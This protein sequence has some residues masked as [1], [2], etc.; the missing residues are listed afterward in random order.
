MARITPVQ[1]ELSQRIHWLVR[2]RWIASASVL[3][4]TLAATKVLDLPLDPLPLYLIAAAIAIYNSWFLIALKWTQ[5]E[6]STRHPAT[7]RWIAN[8]QIL[9]DLIFLTLVIHFSGGA[10]NPFAFYYVFHVVISALLLSRG[11]TFLMATAASVLFG[12]L[13]LAESAGLLPFQPLF[14]LEWIDPSRSAYLVSAALFV[15]CTTIYLVAYMATSI[16]A[17]LRE[18]D[19]E[20]LLLS[21]E[22]EA[23]ARELEQACQVLAE[24]E[25]LKSQYTRKVAHEIRAPMA[26]I[27]STLR[28]VLEGILGEMPDKQREMIARAERRVQGLLSL[29][30]D[31]LTLSRTR[32]SQQLS[33]AKPVDLVDLVEKVVSLQ[34][35]RAADKRINLLVHHSGQVMEVVA[36]PESL[37]QVVTNLVANAINYTPRWGSVQVRLGL[38]ADGIEL[39]VADTGIGIAPDD[40]PKIFNEF[41]RAPNA[42]TYSEEGTG[43]GLS[44]VRSVIDA[45]GGDIQVESTVGQGTTFRIRL[46]RGAGST[47][48]TGRDD[49]GPSGRAPS[50][51]SHM[52]QG[53][54]QM[55]VGAAAQQDIRTMAKE[56][57]KDWVSSLL[58]LLQNHGPVYGP[59]RKNSG[60]VF[61][62]IAAP[63][64]LALEYGTTVLPPKKLL[65]KP[66]ETLFSARLDKGF[67]IQEPAPQEPQVLFGVHSCDLS[68]IMLLDKVYRQSYVDPI[69]AARRDSTLIVAMSCVNPP[70]DRC[71]CGSMGTG[72]SPSAGYDLLFT[73]LGD[74]VLL[75]IGSARGAAVV[76]ELDWAD[77]SDETRARKDSLLADCR[78]RMPR[79]MNTTGLPRLLNENMDHP[80]WM[81]L[82][83]R[84][85]S[86]ANCAMSCPSCYCYNVVDQIGLDVS[87]VQRTRSWDA[88]LLL[89]FAEV[90]GG[91]F[92]KERDARVKQFMYH[93]LSYWV[94]QYGTFGCV[95]CG[96]CINA[97]PAGIDITE[98]AREIR[99]EAR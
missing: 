69:Y 85:L 46:P 90:H 64:D 74:T 21:S 5:G 52:E 58:P 87:T 91:N 53:G 94:D 70:Y 39:L 57:G 7:P 50:P 78:D 75:E 12:G 23:K 51:L 28:V 72:P 3:Y 17:R 15:F 83:D 14:R 98:T 22:M 8:G 27:Q 66:M 82:R 43:L 42:R 96:R 77:A 60:Y 19:R 25:R 26:A 55:A 45:I 79:R 30:G 63:A 33:Q 97:C 24:Q 34:A 67:E 6:F 47:D 49:R 44:I 99:G 71:F 81:K 31:L 54:G 62:L 59:T 88:C 4:G 16:V 32:E 36:N 10:A 65:L 1:A 92:R 80:L 2:L 56:H 84:C 95:G 61:S 11:D 20:I 40:L 93:K 89:E 13:V 48:L 38:L 73:D 76:K 29:V 18:R 68:A 9:V 86:C 37:E 35:P 41:Y